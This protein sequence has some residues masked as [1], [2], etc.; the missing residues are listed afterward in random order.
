MIPF[1]RGT[2]DGAVVGVALAGAGGLKEPA[3]SFPVGRAEG[4]F[5]GEE[6]AVARSA[7]EGVDALGAPEGTMAGAAKLEGECSLSA[8]ISDDGALVGVRRSANSA[9]T[10]TTSSAASAATSFR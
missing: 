7:G 4:T 3:S 1:T 5:D 2:S 8:A 6:L 9:A 10:P